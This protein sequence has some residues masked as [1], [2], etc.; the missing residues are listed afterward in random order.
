MRILI[1]SDT[2]G[3]NGSLTGLLDRMQPLNM[4]VHCGDVEGGE[5]YIRQMAKCPVHIVKGNCDFS[6]TL[7]RE[8]F[9]QIGTYKVWLTHGNRQLSLGGLRQLRQDAQEKG[10][11]IVMY[12]HTHMPRIE[13]A[14][15]P[16]QVTLLNPGSLSCP[17]QDGHRPSF[18]LMELDRQGVA[19]Y[20]LNYL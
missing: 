16:G 14:K 1:V 8:E 18:I 4:L 7:P 10:V 17:R 13:L 15:E 2:H 20:H 19:H 6:M 12:G 3:R 5:E 11:D 9:F